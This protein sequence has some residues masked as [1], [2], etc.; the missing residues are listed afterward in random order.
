MPLFICRSKTNMYKEYY[1]E[2]KNNSSHTCR[3]WS[4]NELFKVK[5]HIKFW[6]LVILILHNIEIEPAQLCKWYVSP[7]WRGF[8]SVSLSV[9]VVST[10]WNFFRKALLRYV[11]RRQTL[12]YVLAFSPRLCDVLLDVEGEASVPRVRE[13][14]FR[15]F[16]H[17][18]LAT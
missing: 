9:F 13:L 18:R 3:N 16:I 12:S 10:R 15:T 5:S 7:L 6:V 2:Y 1:S 11:Y 4:E 14:G 17:N 8:L